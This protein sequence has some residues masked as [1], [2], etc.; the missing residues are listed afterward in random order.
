MLL[1]TA[2]PFSAFILFCHVLS[3]YQNW[4][5]TRIKRF[6]QREGEIKGAVETSTGSLVVPSRWLDLEHAFKCQGGNNPNTIEMVPFV[7][8]LRLAML[9]NG[10]VMLPEL[11]LA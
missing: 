6:E 2:V 9:Q 8:L 7:Q 5:L 11:V 3:P 10:R 4:P 1:P